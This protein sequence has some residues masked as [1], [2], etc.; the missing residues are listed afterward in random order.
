MKRNAGQLAFDLAPRP[1]LGAEDFFVGP[2]NMAALGMIERWPDWPHWA[3]IVE[4]P[5]HSGKSHL[6]QVWRQRSGADA[7][8][9]AELGSQNL[10][11]FGEHPAL[12]VENLEGGIGDERVLFHLFNMAREQKGSLLLT[13]RVSPGDLKVALPDLASRLKAAPKVEIGLPDEAILAAVLVK[14][15]ADRQLEVEPSVIEFI[16]KRLERSLAAAQGVVAELDK[17]SLAARRRVTRPLASEV[18]AALG[19]DKASDD[20]S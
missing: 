15:F 1:A 5:A 8:T 17:S 3:L 20:S 4:G 7:V 14:L 13:T 6:G 10:A 11:R 9:A 19:H 18:L 2:G 12:L 16:V